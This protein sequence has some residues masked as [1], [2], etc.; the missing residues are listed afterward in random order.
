MWEPELLLIDIETKT[1]LK[2]LP[3]VHK[4]LAQLKGITET[5]PN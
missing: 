3:R 5:I 4:A 2:K 1:L